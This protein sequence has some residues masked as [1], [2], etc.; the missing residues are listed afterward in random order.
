MDNQSELMHSTGEIVEPEIPDN[1]FEAALIEADV[2]TKAQ[3]WR[4]LLH[5]HD[6]VWQDREWPWRVR[7]DVAGLLWDKALNL[8]KKN[9]IGRAA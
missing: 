7:F 6:H 3:G 1:E 4:M 5:A 2:L 8:C 9:M